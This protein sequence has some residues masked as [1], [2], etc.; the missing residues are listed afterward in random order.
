MFAT[1]G[2]DSSQAL[3]YVAQEAGYYKE[4]GVDVKINIV[5]SA[6]ATSI[7]S[8]QADIGASGGSQAFAI[9]NQGKPTKQLYWSLG[10]R[11]AG[12]VIAKPSITS[13]NQCKTWITSVPGGSAYGWAAAYKKAYNAT[14][15]ITGSADQTLGQNG[16][17]TGQFD[18]SNNTFGQLN[19]SV[20]A[21]KTHFIVD[22]RDANSLPANVKALN[23]LDTSYYALTS[24]IQDKRESL[25]RF[26][27]AINKAVNYMR[28]TPPDQIAALLLQNTNWQ[29][30]TK[31]V[32]AAALQ[33]I[34]FALAPNDGNIASSQW[35]EIVTFNQGA[36]LTYLS[37]TDPKWS[38]ENN[39]DMSYLDAAK[40]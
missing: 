5:G 22:P 34:M 27:K 2:V 33:N 20:V 21:G 11:A 12:F 23:N 18:C 9:T 14:Y 4:F 30:Y 36:G 37:T 28:T 7:T 31:D 24:A 39:V 38:Y 6:I 16:V 13:V 3:V 8:G 25:V 10:N 29:T 26:F 1:T 32:L 17:A 19:P 15:D 40:K 35:N